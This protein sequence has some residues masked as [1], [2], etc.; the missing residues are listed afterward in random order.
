MNVANAAPLSFFAIGC[1]V[2]A[3][4]ILVTYVVRPPLTSAWKLWLLA[5]L[6]VFPI[7]AAL[8]GNVA[9]YEATKQRTF[10]GSCHVMRP[11]ED[12]SN[13]TASRSLASRHGRNA[14]FG[15]Q[16]CHACHADYGMYGT[17]TTKV[18]SL[19]HFFRYYAEYREVPLE[20]SKK[21]IRLSKPYSNDNCMQCHSTRLDLWNKVH[22]HREVLDEVRNGT[23]SC[24]AGGC[25]GP[26]HPFSKQAIAGGAP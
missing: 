13:D 1:A 2:I 26:A 18:G 9:G 14:L 3:A 23:V 20:E 8:G 25:H 17:V 15:A 4:A 19:K 24:M 6:G 7:G 11:Y 22:D 12:D 16:N 5:G 21:K 10:C